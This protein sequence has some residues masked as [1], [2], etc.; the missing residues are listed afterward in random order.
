MDS[1]YMT[2][3]EERGLRAAGLDELANYQ[4]AVHN[5]QS[6][7]H[8]AASSDRVRSNIRDYLDV[9]HL[10]SLKLADYIIGE[11]RPPLA[12]NEAIANVTKYDPYNKLFLRR[13]LRKMKD[14]SIQGAIEDRHWPNDNQYRT[15][16]MII[17]EKPP[18]NRRL[19]RHVGGFMTSRRP[20]SKI[21]RKKH[22][23]A[24]KD[25]NYQQVNN[26]MPPDYKIEQLRRQ[27][28][29]SSENRKKA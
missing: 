20:V 25:Q 11:V 7:L 23:V 12:I 24:Y 10:T 13:N 26:L 1:T 19:G 29:Y 18:P 8:E 3:E 9:D 16:F 28:R 5:P 6:A 15:A 22:F 4:L 27:A 14:E 17:G 21:Y 2:N